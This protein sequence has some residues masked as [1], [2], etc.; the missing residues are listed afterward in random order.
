MSGGPR[1]SHTTSP[2]RLTSTRL[3]PWGKVPSTLPLGRLSAS[4]LNTLLG[5]TACLKNMGQTAGSLVT[6]LGNQKPT[7]IQQRGHFQLR[8]TGKLPSIQ[9][10]LLC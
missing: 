2:A 3:I 8:A 1:S 5:A 9:H 4:P 7:P 6:Y 10:V